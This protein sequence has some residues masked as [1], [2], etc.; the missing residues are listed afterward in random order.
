MIEA[1]E[2][3]RNIARSCDTVGR[4]GGDEFIILLGGLNFAA[5]ALPVAENLLNRFRDA[6]RVD[7]RELMLT[8]SLGI[9][10]FPEDGDN[11]SELLRKADSAMYHSKDLGRNTYSFFTNAMNRDVTRRLALEEQ[12]HGALER[13]EFSIVYQ[14]QVEMS[15]GRIIGAEALLRWQNPAL[16]AVPPDEFIPVAEQTGLIV[17]IGQFVIV[18]ATSMIA[19]WQRDYDPELRVAVN[20]SPL[21]FQNPELVNF[22]EQSITHAGIASKSLELEITE[23]VLMSEHSYIE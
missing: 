5:D 10:I 8:T 7:G 16:G 4:L 3:L 15:S 18:K 19:K 11:S 2:R 6:F 22:I 23:G 1:A 17:M 13:N 20:L 12:I 14:P 9:S 21:Q